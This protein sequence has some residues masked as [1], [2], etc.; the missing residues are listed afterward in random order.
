MLK[1]SP[2]HATAVALKA[3][4]FDFAKTST[5]ETLFT[6]STSGSWLLY[7]KLAK[8]LLIDCEQ[9]DNCCQVTISVLDFTKQLVETG[10]NI[11]LQQLQRTFWQ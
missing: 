2:S 10:E 6:G 5:F 11:Q 8:M 9:N 3:N 4:I 7:G 1:C